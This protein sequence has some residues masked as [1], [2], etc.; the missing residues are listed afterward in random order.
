MRR[1]C[2]PKLLLGT[3]ALV[4]SAVLGSPPAA[5]ADDGAVRYHQT[6][7]AAAHDEAGQPTWASDEASGAGAGQPAGDGAGQP[8]GPEDGGQHPGAPGASEWGGQQPGTPGGS[9]WGGG[10]PKAEPVAPTCFE[11]VVKRAGE[12]SWTATLHWKGKPH[13]RE[14]F[15]GPVSIF[16]TE[17]V[18]EANPERPD[19]RGRWTRVAGDVRVDPNGGWTSTPIRLISTGEWSLSAV[20]RDNRFWLVDVVR[21]P[22]K[23][24]PSAGP[25]KLFHRPKLP[26]T[27]TSGT[28]LRLLGATGSGGLA[29]GTLLLVATRRRRHVA[30]R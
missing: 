18:D 5:K 26:Q 10:A 25:A 27:G 20:P 13:C 19:Q 30:A 14:T 4:L 17:G 28:S 6:S 24:S 11:T 2:R 23:G 29:I 3:A 22:A 9:E 16:Y 15:T 21:I 7:V 1:L 8:P 12:D